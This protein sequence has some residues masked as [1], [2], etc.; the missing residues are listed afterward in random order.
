MQL[1]GIM[2]HCKGNSRAYF[3]VYI[4]ILS[5][6]SRH[7]LGSASV[8]QREILGC[9]RRTRRVEEG[10]SAEEEEFSAVGWKAC[11]GGRGCSGA[12]VDI[13]GECVDVVWGTGSSVGLLRTLPLWGGGHR[14]RRP[15]LGCTRACILL[16]K[17]TTVH[18]TLLTAKGWCTAIDLLLQR[19][20]EKTPAGL[21]WGSRAPI[22]NLASEPVEK[23]NKIDSIELLK[24]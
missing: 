4:Y 11:C 21:C 20:P 10:G 9:E 22:H 17:L 18:V 6:P 24:Y 13:G 5:F 3:P 23:E 16:S 2:W 7:T 15:V 12:L 14:R 1:P 8:L 19:L